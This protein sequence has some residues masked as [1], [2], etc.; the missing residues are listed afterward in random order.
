MNATSKIAPAKI[1]VPAEAVDAV[2]GSLAPKNSVGRAS[3]EFYEAALR[4]AGIEDPDSLTFAESVEVTRRL[5]AISA[6]YRRAVAKDAAASRE[7]EREAA[8]KAREAEKAKRE[9]AE[10]EILKAK[11]AAKGIS[12]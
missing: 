2:R 4:E 1:A 9:L 10:I 8:R 11:L 12:V 5:Y 3:V 7:A 6:D